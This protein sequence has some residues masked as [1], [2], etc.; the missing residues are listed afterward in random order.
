MRWCNVWCNV[1]WA[2]APRS[3][4]QLT[5]DYSPLFEL[6]NPK[7]RERERELRREG[8]KSLLAYVKGVYVLDS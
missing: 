6:S 3:P 1:W 2:R 8:G 5:A 4:A 7:Q